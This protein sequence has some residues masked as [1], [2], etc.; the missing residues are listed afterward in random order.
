MLRVSIDL[1]PLTRSPFVWY[2]LIVWAVSIGIV[3]ADLAWDKPVQ[4]FH[5][6]P[7]DRAVNAHFTFKNT[8]NETVIIKKV[9]TSCGCT[10]ASLAKT[11]YAPG[12]TGDI[13]AK[14]SL[15]TWRGLQRKSITVTSEAKQEWTLELRC[16][17]HEALT[18]SPELVYWKVGSAADGKI[19]KVSSLP[20]HPILVKSVKSSNVRIKATLD[21]VQAGVEYAIMVTPSDTNQAAAAELAI[22]TETQSEVKRNYK[23]FVRIK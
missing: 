5:A 3:R 21:T 22:E 8:S 15:V 20:G 18:V 14:M 6:V 16:W 17:I 23:V 1:Q 9:A 19:V 10:T 4:E 7:E 2:C 13:E 12:E 11:M